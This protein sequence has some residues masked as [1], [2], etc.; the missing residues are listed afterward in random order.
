MKFPSKYLG[1][2]IWGNSRENFSKKK[3]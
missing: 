1:I 2:T 3:L